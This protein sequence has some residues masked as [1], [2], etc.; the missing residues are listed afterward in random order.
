ML[1]VWNDSPKTG[2][3]V[4]GEVQLE[5]PSAGT[6]LHSLTVGHGEVDVTESALVLTV[7]I[8]EGSIYFYVFFLKMACVTPFCKILPVKSEKRWTLIK[9]TLK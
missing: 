5:F 8:Q 7:T 3:S 1:Q 2:F 9:W 4:L 6:T